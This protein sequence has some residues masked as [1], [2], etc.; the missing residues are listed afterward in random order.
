MFFSCLWIGPRLKSALMKIVK[1]PP[2]R[3]PLRDYGK[4]SIVGIGN[5][6]LS[7][8]TVSTNSAY[9]GKRLFSISIPV[10]SSYT[11]GDEIDSIVRALKLASSDADIVIAT[12]G[13]GPTDDDLTRQA[14]AKFLDSELQLQEELLDKI[15]KRFANRNLQMPAKNKIQ[16]YI[17]AGAKALENNLGTAPGIMAEY[18]CPEQ[19]R[20]T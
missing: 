13:L 15:Q 10:V 19:G 2:D 17:P 5:E 11:I 18:T 1:M 8:Q 7:G 16:A 6:L 12:G 3:D 14:F 20:V 9:L 4:A